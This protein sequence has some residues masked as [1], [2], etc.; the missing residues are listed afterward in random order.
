[1]ALLWAQSKVDD[2]PRFVAVVRRL[3][4]HC[5]AFPSSL[6]LFVSADDVFQYPVFGVFMCSYPQALRLSTD[7]ILCLLYSHAL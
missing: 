6:P 7:Y 5:P 1:M 4:R 2:P 3:S